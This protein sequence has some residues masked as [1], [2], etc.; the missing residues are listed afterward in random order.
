MKIKKAIYLSSNTDLKFCPKSDLPEFAFIGRSNVGKSSLINMLTDNRKLAKTSGTPGKTQLINHFL[1]DNSWHLVDLPGYSW[2]KVSRQQRQKWI[3]MI[4]KYLLGRENLQCVFVMIDSRIVAQKTDLEFMQ[5]LG[6]SKIPFVMIFTK[7]DKQS[8]S[9]TLR[10]IDNYKN[11]MLEVWE[12][13]P[14]Y[15]LASAITK[16]GK[17]ELLEFIQEIKGIRK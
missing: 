6:L 15:F 3:N 11:I 8:K 16:V 14:E 13:M 9:K 12:K 2:A 5:W 10:L 4:R 7:I 17:E 1:I